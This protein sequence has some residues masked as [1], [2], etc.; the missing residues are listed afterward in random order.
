M[1]HAEVMLGARSARQVD[2]QGQAALPRVRVRRHWAKPTK[3]K[4][5]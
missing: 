4:A 5:L 2:G 3:K 1:S